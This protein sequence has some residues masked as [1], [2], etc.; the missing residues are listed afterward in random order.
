MNA[1]LTPPVTDAIRRALDNVT[2]DDKYTLDRGRVLFSQIKNGQQIELQLGPFRRSKDFFVAPSPQ[3]GTAA[4][5]TRL[6]VEDLH[7]L[8]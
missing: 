2:L 8:Q 7:R 3:A 5:D 6:L 1:P 4:R